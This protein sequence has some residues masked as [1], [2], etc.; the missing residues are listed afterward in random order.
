MSNNKLTT[1]RGK[2][3]IDEERMNAIRRSKAKQMLNKEW[4]CD[5]CDN[6]HNYS[7]R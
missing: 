3:T 2:Y 4:W 6:N 1:K 7:W 5:I